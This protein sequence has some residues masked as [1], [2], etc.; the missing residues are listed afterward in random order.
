MWGLAPSGDTECI[1]LSLFWILKRTSYLFVAVT[2]THQVSEVSCDQEQLEVRE[3][4]MIHNNTLYFI[5]TVNTVSTWSRW[6]PLH[7]NVFKLKPW[8]TDA[9]EGDAHFVLCNSWIQRLKRPTPGT[10][11]RIIHSVRVPLLIP[12]NK[13]KNNLKRHMRSLPSFSSTADK[14]HGEHSARRRGLDLFTPWKDM[15][16]QKNNNYNNFKYSKKFPQKQPS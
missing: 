7:Y 13:L 5:Q 4:L 9:N 6:E 12:I 15:M 2:L 16:L 8:S 11:Q 3:E 14:R 1:T 10:K